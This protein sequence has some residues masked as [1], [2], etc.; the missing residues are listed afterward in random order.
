M[1][2]DNFKTN[3][4]NQKKEAKQPEVKDLSQKAIKLSHNNQESDEINNK[5][6]KKERS[7]NQ[8]WLVLQ[9]RVNHLESQLR[10]AI[11][12]KENLKRI[13]Q[14]D[15]DEKSNYAITSFARDIISSCDNLERAI[16]NLNESDPVHDGIKMTWKEITNVLQRNGIEKVDPINLVFDSNLHQTISEVIDNEKEPGTVVKVLQC[17]YTIKKRLLRPAM[18]VISKKSSDSEQESE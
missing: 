9:E 5:T 14:R 1:V 4:S 17:G 13:M 6:Q 12:D 10:L 15:I 2:E 16:D 3:N 18:V 8:D 11:A 7:I